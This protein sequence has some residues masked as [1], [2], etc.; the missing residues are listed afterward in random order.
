MPAIKLDLKAAIVADKAACVPI[1]DIAARYG[2][3]SSAV[4]KH[5]RSA[6]LVT[7][8]EP[9]WSD[10]MIATLRQ[11]WCD[12]GTTTQIAAV[13][14]VTKNAVCGK[15]RCLD[16]PSREHAVHEAGKRRHQKKD[17]LPA[18]QVVPAVVDTGLPV[19]P[20]SARCLFPMWTGRPVFR[21]GEPWF[22]G[23]LRQ[24][25]SYCADHGR[26]CYERPRGMEAV[27]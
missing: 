4:H 11:M 5:L 17:P 10:P 15:R 13:L 21:D 6:H 18:V 1:K 22:C 9:K 26:R 24:R 20:L 3:S 2:I 25:G 14:G 19:L 23:A 7:T 27:E 8:H 16:L 12:G